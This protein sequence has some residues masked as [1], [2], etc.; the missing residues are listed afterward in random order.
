MLVH[1]IL[2][3]QFQ[4]IAVL[5]H[6]HP[7][8]APSCISMRASSQQSIARCCDSR[9]G[10]APICQA[11][12]KMARSCFDTGSDSCDRMSCRTGRAAVHRRRLRLQCLFLSFL[13]VTGY[14]PHTFPSPSPFMINK[15]NIPKYS[16][17]RT[18]RYATYPHTQ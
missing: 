15:K 10:I 1:N 4:N 14:S 5:P 16:L 8:S 7:T 17:N 2:V 11:A 13:E 9:V 12:T 3:L 18:V 6:P